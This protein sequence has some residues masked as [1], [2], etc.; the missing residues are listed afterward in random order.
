MCEGESGR[1]MSVYNW[2]ELRQTRALFQW[3]GRLSAPPSRHVS[4]REQSRNAKKG[5]SFRMPTGVGLRLWRQHGWVITIVE[6]AFFFEAV[7]RAKIGDTL[8]PPLLACTSFCK[9]AELLAVDQ[10]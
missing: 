6:R 9:N 4:S 2:E 8:F 3:R 1:E 5:K 7:A 10:S